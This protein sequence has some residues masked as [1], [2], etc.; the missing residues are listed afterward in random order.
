[1]IYGF[2]GAD[3]EDAADTCAAANDI[4][5]WVRCYPDRRFIAGNDNPPW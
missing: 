5:D 1:M 4:L 2:L 3:Y